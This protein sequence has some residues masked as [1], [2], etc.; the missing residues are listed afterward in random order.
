MTLS[1]ANPLHKLKTLCIEGNMS[2]KSSLKKVSL[3]PGEK[4]KKPPRVCQAD[5]KY[6]SLNLQSVCSKE[7][8][9]GGM[10]G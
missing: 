6:Q 10:K 5:I 3:L 4:K 7:G 2:L 8:L 1:S 9:D